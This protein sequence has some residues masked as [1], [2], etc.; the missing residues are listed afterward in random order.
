[1]DKQELLA[2]VDSLVRSDGQQLVCDQAGHPAGHVCL[3]A[4]GEVSLPLLIKELG[5]RYGQLRNLVAGGYA[6]PTVDEQTGLPLLA[7]FREQLVDMRAWKCGRWWIGCGT[8][9][10]GDGVR[11]VVLV[12]EQAAP[13][14]DEVPEGLPE[15]ASWVDQVVA[16]TGWPADR[17]RVVDWA[18][19]EARL[20]T[21]LPGDYKRLVERFGYGAFDDYLGLFLPGGPMGSI[22]IVEFNEWWAQWAEAHD[23]NSWEPYQLYPAP[24]GLL[25]WAG[26]EQ[27]DDFYWLTEGPDPDS[28]PILA[29]VED[30]GRW[31]RFDGSTAEY[32]YRLL[33]DRRLPFSTARDFD[34]HWFESYEKLEAE[35]D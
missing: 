29:T 26:T 5:D 32:V 8:V 21:V 28:W 24:N 4:S 19:V 22:D 7:P 35:S 34:T 31:Y 2:A 27:R 9:R 18:A 15:G 12:T 10:A 16:V 3:T 1:M 33:T 11:L 25:Q 13:P 17:V 30:R 20:G 6:D 14:P 23:A